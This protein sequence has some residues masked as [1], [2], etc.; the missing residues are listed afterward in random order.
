M[1]IPFKQL[2]SQLTKQLASLYL[3]ATDETFLAQQ[4]RD[5]IYQAAKQQG[6]GEK[7]LINFDSSTT[8]NDIFSSLQNFNL[9]SDKA[10]TDLRYPNVKFNAADSKLLETY[11][12]YADGNNLIVLSTNKL[13][14]AQQRSKWF[15]SIEKK[16]AVIQIWPIS[17]RELPSWLK[18]QFD[19]NQLTINSDAIQ[20]LA[21]LSEGNLLA[22]HQAV[23]K[24]RMLNFNR[25]I[26]ATDIAE[27]VSDNARFNVFDLANYMLQGDTKH[28]IRIIE[29]LRQTGT[30]PILVLWAIAREL[31]LLIGMAEQIEQGVSLQQAISS[32]WQSRKPLVKSALTR[33]DLKQL[34]A[35]LQSA[36]QIDKMIKGLLPNNAWQQL[37]RIGLS[38]AGEKLPS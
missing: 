17:A 1:L 15:K 9:F 3:I 30:E 36:T 2:S 13:S 11:L 24:C 21:S 25:S 26:T 27:V 23:E 19:K 6:Y 35:L 5:S 4:A 32:E 7:K 14:K 12:D 8:W 10:V 22:A 33:L 31:R 16:A 20:L 34:L 18:T 29:G 38:I 28:V 37:T